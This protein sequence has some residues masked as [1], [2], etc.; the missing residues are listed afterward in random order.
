MTLDTGM[1]CPLTDRVGSLPLTS[2]LVTVPVAWVETATAVPVVSVAAILI[3]YLPSAE[4][5]PAVFRPMDQ[6]IC[7]YVHKFN[8]SS[9]TL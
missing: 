3:V 9:F 1:F 7:V 4:M 8:M 6:N 2:T 5:V